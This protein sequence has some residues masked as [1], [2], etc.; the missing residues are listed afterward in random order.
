MN[1][2]PAT[3]VVTRWPPL[4]TGAQRP[5]WVGVRDALLTL[6]AWFILAWLLRDLVYLAYDFLRPPRFELTIAAPDL[7]ALWERLQYFVMASATLI[8]SLALW[9]AIDRRRLLEAER[10]PQPSPLTIGDE[11]HRAG[12]DEKS[13]GEARTHKLTKVIFRADGSIA[14]FQ[15]GDRV[16]R[17]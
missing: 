10:I 16:A 14:S 4:V 8:A 15:E 7:G 5:Y 1:S 3:P 13:I 2:S 9:A 12:V 11:A 6:M 17:A